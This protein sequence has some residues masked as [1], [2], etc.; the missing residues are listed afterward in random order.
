MPASKLSIEATTAESGPS[1]RAG[2][3]E[4]EQDRASK[5]GNDS[6]RALA[7]LWTRI[8][9][10]KHVE[11][12]GL[13]LNVSSAEESSGFSPVSTPNIP[14]VVSSTM[15]AAEII[16]VFDSQHCP[17][18]SQELDLQNCGGVAIAGGSFGDI[19]RG[20]LRNGD[21]V[22]I[23]CAR[24]FLDNTDQ[25][26]E[27]LKSAA[28][29]LYAWSKCQ[30]ICVAELLGVALFRNQLAMISRWTGRGTLPQYITNNPRV[31][32][33]RLCHQIVTGLDYLHRIGVVHGD[34][35]GANVLIS[36]GGHAQLTDFGSSIFK[37]STMVFTGESFKPS[38]SLR[39]AAPELLDETV[40]SSKEADIYAL[41]M[42]ILETITGEIPYA[43]RTDC[44]VMVAVAV[45]KELPTRPESMGFELWNILLEC[46]RR[47]PL[48]RPT[49][50]SVFLS[51]D[52]YYGHKVR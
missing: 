44:N 18:I 31:N 37:S 12:E 14:K 38:F 36:E 45:K 20:K 48:A 17:D 23:K 32:R 51:V 30:H 46:W 40:K 50:T 35:K 29:E 7:R 13:P 24:L 43:G 21:L 19:Y 27:V 10:R 25:S 33:I 6:D 42:T 8:K 39:W 16:A 41:G 49:A 34:I 4:G 47:E 1:P 52:V 28:R 22:A 11:V 5:D 15:S 26:Q 9:R 2:E 3:N